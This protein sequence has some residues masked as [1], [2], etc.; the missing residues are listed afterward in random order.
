MSMNRKLVRALIRQALN[1]LP[2]GKPAFC[3]IPRHLADPANDNFA[4]VTEM[5]PKERR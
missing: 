3:R 4:G 5:T 2:K 1:E